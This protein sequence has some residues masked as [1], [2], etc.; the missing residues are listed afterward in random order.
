MALLYLDENFYYFLILVDDVRMP[1]WL[2]YISFEKM[3][4]L[5]DL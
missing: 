2:M 4:E 3:K 1:S 5:F